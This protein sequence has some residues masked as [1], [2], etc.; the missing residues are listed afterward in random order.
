[1]VKMNITFFCIIKWTVDFN[2]GNSGKVLLVFHKLMQLLLMYS[3]FHNYM[4][5]MKLTWKIVHAQV[6]SKELEVQ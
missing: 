6:W 4:K 5:E 3:L 2:L 1:M